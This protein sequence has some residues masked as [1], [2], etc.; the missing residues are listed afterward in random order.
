[1][2]SYSPQTIYMGYQTDPYQP[3]E[4]QFHQTRKVLELL[5][6]NGFSAS[7]PTKSDLVLRDTD[8]KKK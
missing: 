4:A 5:L 2:V 7:I 1:M 8:I 3:S 6:E